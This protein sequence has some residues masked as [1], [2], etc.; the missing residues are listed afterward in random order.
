M[1]KKEVSPLYKPPS[2]PGPIAEEKGTLED[3]VANSMFDSRR[4]LLGNMKFENFTYTDR[5]SSALTKDS[6]F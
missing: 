2:K 1:M 6:D 5:S 3:T 4:D